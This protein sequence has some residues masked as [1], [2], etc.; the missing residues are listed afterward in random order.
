MLNYKQSIYRAFYNLPIRYRY[1]VN[2]EPTIG[3]AYKH[4]FGGLA[5]KIILTDQ[6][7][8]VEK[9]IFSN[10]GY[11][12]TEFTLTRADGSTETEGVRKYELATDIGQL[13]E[14]TSRIDEEIK[15]QTLIKLSNLDPDVQRDKLTSEVKTIPYPGTH[16]L[17]QDQYVLNIETAVILVGNG[18]LP[19]T[20]EE[21]SASPWIVEG[22]AREL[23]LYKDILC[24]L[25]IFDEGS[26]NEYVAP[27]VFTTVKAG[28]ICFREI[29]V[30]GESFD[31]NSTKFRGAKDKLGAEQAKKVQQLTYLIDDKFTQTINLREDTGDG[32]T[33]LL[34]E[35]GKVIGLVGIYNKHYTRT[36]QF[37][38][39]ITCLNTNGE[40]VLQS[41]RLISPEAFGFTNGF[42][43]TK[44]RKITFL[45]TSDKNQKFQEKLQGIELM[46]CGYVN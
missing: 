41:G 29:M 31:R 18:K 15:K 22:H 20:F 38:S 36:M 12:D 45:G 43:K 40:F 3:T 33:R 23:S 19:T 37:E 30:E 32:L 28:A 39:G 13:D 42:V 4:G 8:G 5:F 25:T 2:G 27:N 26:A 1:L 11:T 17:M 14:I 46:T 7:T 9:V 16:F 21:R 34:D 35:N 24:Q 44:S 10:I 6:S